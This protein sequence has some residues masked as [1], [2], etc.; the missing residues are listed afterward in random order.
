LSQGKRVSWSAS[1]TVGFVDNTV[2]N[3]QFNKNP[4]RFQNYGI[5]FIAIY[6]DGEQIFS[7]PLQPDFARN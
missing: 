5:N 6:K 2:F 7:K 1:Q 4:F 3:G